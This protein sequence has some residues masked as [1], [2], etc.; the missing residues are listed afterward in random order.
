MHIL[1][2]IK[3]EFRAQNER[4]NEWYGGESKALEDLSARMLNEEKAFH[5]GIIHPNQS[6]PTLL[7]APLSLSAHLRFGCISVR[8]FFWTLYDCYHQVSQ[9]V[10][11]LLFGLFCVCTE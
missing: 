5:M 8:K 4:I 3:P 10:S 11:L 1:A 2:D 9:E 6:K 7:G